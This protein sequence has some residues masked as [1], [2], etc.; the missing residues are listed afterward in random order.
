[1]ASLQPETLRSATQPG[2]GHPID[3]L[4]QTSC[5]RAASNGPAGLC[6]GLLAG[7]RTNTY[8]YSKQSSPHHGSHLQLR[9]LALAL[10]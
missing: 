8:S 6:Q 7:L 5:S 2:L 9:C 10:L 1:M 4:E 3:L